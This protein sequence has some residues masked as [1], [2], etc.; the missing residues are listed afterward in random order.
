[1]QD[2]FSFPAE[3]EIKL[4]IDNF[5]YIYINFLINRKLEKIIIIHYE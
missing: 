4:E 3:L 5:M 2:F 1:M